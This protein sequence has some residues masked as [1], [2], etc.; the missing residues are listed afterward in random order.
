[1]ILV[2]RAENFVMLSLKGAIKFSDLDDLSIDAKGAEYL[3]KLPEDK[4]MC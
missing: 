1:M 2:S 3:K 4:K